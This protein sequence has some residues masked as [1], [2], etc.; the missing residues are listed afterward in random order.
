MRKRQRKKKLKGMTEFRVGKLSPNTV[1]RIRT[2]LA[3]PLSSST[4]TYSQA[5]INRAHSE[6]L[7][8]FLIQNGSGAWLIGADMADQVGCLAAGSVV[9]I[10]PGQRPLQFVQFAGIMPSGLTPDQQ[11]D[12][13]DAAEGANSAMRTIT[14]V[15]RAIIRQEDRYGDRAPSPSALQAMWQWL[16]GRSA[17]SRQ[18]PLRHLPNP[19]PHPHVPRTE[20]AVERNWKT[21]A[22]DAKGRQ[23]MVPLLGDRFLITMRETLKGFG[24]Q[25]T[26]V[27]HCNDPAI[28]K[29]QMTAAEYRQWMIDHEADLDLWHGLRLDRRL[30]WDDFWEERAGG[31]DFSGR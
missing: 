9:S 25:Q 13:M 14:G 20:Y 11:N 19:T 12:F 16:A 24:S 31:E 2:L 23:M 17:P 21:D 4:W 30:G 15:P 8:G 28:P 22:D 7:D 26:W 29:A 10:G 6:L 27:A 3:E 5:A 18:R 1:N